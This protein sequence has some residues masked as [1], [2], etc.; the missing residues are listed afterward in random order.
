MREQGLG[1]SAGG[2]TGGQCPGRRFSPTSWGWVSRA[3]KGWKEAA[4][5]SADIDGLLSHTLVRPGSEHLREMGVSGRDLRDNG[6]IP[7]L[8]PKMITSAEVKMGNWE[9]GGPWG[10]HR[11]Q[12]GR[13]WQQTNGAGKEGEEMDW[14]WRWR[15]GGQAWEDEDSDKQARLH[16]PGVSADAA[17]WE[18]SLKEKQL[19]DLRD[20]AE[21]KGFGNPCGGGV[22]FPVTQ[23]MTD[24]CCR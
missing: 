20:P 14:G 11:S 18:G 8:C 19:R 7:D 12:P 10:V 5:D 22:V 15:E 9:V 24:S 21:A 13:C 6:I 23:G 17:S 16:E 4:Q 3:F 2:R 1:G